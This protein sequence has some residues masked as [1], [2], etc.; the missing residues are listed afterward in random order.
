M[1]IQKD[2]NPIYFRSKIL[3]W[4]KKNFVNYPWR[5]TSNLWHAITAEIMLQRTRADQVLPVYNDF[6]KK[7]GNPIDFQKHVLSTDENI[8]KN[9]GL[10]WRHETF[11]KTVNYLVMNGLPG[12]KDGFLKVP[13]IGEYVASAVLSFHFDRREVL[14]D[15]NIVRLLG[16]FFGFKFDNETRRKKWL[17]VIAENVTPKKNVSEFNYGILDFSMQICSPKPNCQICIMCRKCKYFNNEL[18][19]K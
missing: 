17:R 14:I 5:S 1:A 18:K 4:G 19:N 7:F 12:D 2:I 10:I 8:F 16:R 13:G 15:S 9:L 3:I 6:V 11:K